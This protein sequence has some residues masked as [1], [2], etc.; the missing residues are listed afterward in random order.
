MCIGEGPG[1]EEDR[2]GRPF[3]G[4]AGQY[5]D[6]WLGAIDLDRK[7]DCFIGNIVKCRPPGNRDPL[8]DESGACI[9]YLQQQIQILR[10][11]VIVGLGRIATQI[12]LGTTDGIGV[13]RGRWFEYN[14]IP[15]LPTFHPSAVLRNSDLRRA[16]W[17]DMKKI[18]SRLDDV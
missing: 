10:P 17:E 15:L 16:V 6:R 7:A 11:K 5:L 2:G 1:A 4:P 8:P 18:R 3:V 9:P 14:G 13:L 12:L